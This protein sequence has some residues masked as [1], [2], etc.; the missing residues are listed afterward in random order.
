M[1]GDGRLSVAIARQWS[2]SLFLRNLSP[3]AGRAIVVDLRLPGAPAGGTRAAIGA[4]ARVSLADG[5][6]VTSVVDGGSGHGGKRAPEIQ[7]GLGQVPADQAFN[8]EFKWRDGEGFHTR[9]AMLKPGRYR[10]TLG[11]QETAQLE[12]ARIERTP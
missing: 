1:F 3:N 11:V 10:I 7:L 5:R 4:E 6:V 2:P 8:V 12:P 9:T